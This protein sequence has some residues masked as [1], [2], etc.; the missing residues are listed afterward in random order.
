MRDQAAD[1][2]SL[3]LISLAHQSAYSRTCW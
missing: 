2:I 3:V 1:D